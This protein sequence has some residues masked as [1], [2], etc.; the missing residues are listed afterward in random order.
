MQVTQQVYVAEE[1][2]RNAH[3]KFEADTHSQREVEKALG[4]VK[5]EKTQLAKKLKTSE[6][7]RLSAL[8]GLK[9]AETQAKDQRKL[10][11]TTEL[12]LATEK[13]TVLSLKA[14]LQ[15][16]K[17]ETQAVKEA[18][19][20][21][22]IATYE[23]GVLETKQRLAEEVAEVCKDYYTITWNEALNSAG[24][25]ANF[26]LRKVENMFYPK[27]IREVPA[28][29][30]STAPPLPP[31]EQAS[32]IQ[33]LTLDAEA[34]T[35]VGKGKGDLPLAKDA[36]PEDSLTIQD[37]VS[38]AK[39][40]EKSKAREAMIK[41][42]DTKEDPQPTKK[43]LQGFFFIF[44]CTSFCF[45]FSWLLPLLVTYFAFKLMNELFL[46]ISC[47]FTLYAFVPIAIAN[48]FELLLLHFQYI[49][50]VIHYCHFKKF[51]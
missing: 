25:P 13:A 19:K 3:N 6:H 44:L 18:A 8:V 45:I 4:T 32:S 43:Q 30:P 47:V 48:K 50:T 31:P 29:L 49:L 28:N 40:A 11:Y 26:K 38:Q 9:T 16:A 2:V 24:V 36:Q 5:E 14:E 37:V 51:D 21:A 42:A 39:V 22:K 20:A 33:D 12:N 17:A 7:E 27:H 23:R 1:C 34:S 10:L 41:A 46:L 35:G 15:K